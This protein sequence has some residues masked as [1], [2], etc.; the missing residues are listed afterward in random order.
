MKAKQLKKKKKNCYYH[1]PLA[2]SNPDKPP[3]LHS[4]CR[5]HAACAELH[6][7]THTTHGFITAPELLIRPLTRILKGSRGA[8][9]AGGGLR[10]C[11]VRWGAWLE[12]PTVW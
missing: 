11:A 10:S 5:S 3:D 6:T 1:G 7:G 8:W 9:A 2:V 12:D 4:P